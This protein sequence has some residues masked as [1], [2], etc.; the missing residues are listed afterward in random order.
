MEPSKA[1]E[2]VRIDL[3]PSQADDIKATTGLDVD[4]IQLT[5]EEL[6]QRI[7]PTVSV[8]QPGLPPSTMIAANSNET[9]LVS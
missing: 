6:E 1:H 5:A 9:M 3:T 8:P 2:I 4:A 7:A